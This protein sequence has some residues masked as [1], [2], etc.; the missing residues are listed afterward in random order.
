M[1]VIKN[2]DSLWL[3]MFFELTRQIQSE[4]LEQ[5]F[6]MLGLLGDAAFANFHAG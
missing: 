4:V 1:W 5:N 2:L 6:L 3:K